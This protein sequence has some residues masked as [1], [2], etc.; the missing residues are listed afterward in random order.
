M[1]SVVIWTLIV[2]LSLAIAAGLLILPFAWAAS[3]T[4]HFY[5]ERPVLLAMRQ[6][7]NGDSLKTS[8]A[9]GVLLARF[10]LGTDAALAAAALSA[11]GFG[12]QRLPSTRPATNAAGAQLEQRAAEIRA[13][14]GLAQDT[15]ASPIRINCQLLAPAQLGSTRWMI[16]FDFSDGDRLAGVALAI[17]NIF[18]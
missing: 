3:K 14:L 17:M 18:L 11:E 16:D 7:W 15:Q 10:P 6:A 13:Q 8:P 2:G 12:C 9:R 1:R 4:E 5:R